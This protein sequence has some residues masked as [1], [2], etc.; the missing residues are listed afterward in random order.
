MTGKKMRHSLVFWCVYVLS[1][2]RDVLRR[3]EINDRKRRM[4]EDLR[5]ND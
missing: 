3:I 2:Q 5:K 4:R 1:G